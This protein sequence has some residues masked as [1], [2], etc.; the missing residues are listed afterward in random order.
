MIEKLKPYVGND[1]V[2]EDLEDDKLALIDG[3]DEA[4]DPQV[5]AQEILEQM[6]WINCHVP[7]RSQRKRK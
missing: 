2:Q 6:T 4:T 1:S 7:K 3:D 5:D